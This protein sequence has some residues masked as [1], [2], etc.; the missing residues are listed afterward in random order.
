MGKINKI[1]VN[2]Q[3]K[4]EEIALPSVNKLSVVAKTSLILMPFVVNPEKSHP[5]LAFSR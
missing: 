3:T 4:S 1:L 2:N 5:F